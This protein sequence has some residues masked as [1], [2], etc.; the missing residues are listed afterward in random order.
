MWTERE[1]QLPPE[2]SVPPANTLLFQL[3]TKPPH[4][5]LPFSAQLL[6]PVIQIKPH[7]SNLP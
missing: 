7:C 5:G 2:P 1:R 4:L 6:Q 3:G